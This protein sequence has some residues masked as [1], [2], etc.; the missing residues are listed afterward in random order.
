[1]DR[2]QL[3]AG[4]AGLSFASAAFAQTAQPQSSAQGRRRGHRGNG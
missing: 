2:R 4:I 1:M 3:L